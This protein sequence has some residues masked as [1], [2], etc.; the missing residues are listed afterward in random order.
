MIL[1]G[2][3]GLRIAVHDV[4]G[5]TEGAGFF[6]PGEEKAK[7]RVDNYLWVGDREK[8]NLPKDSEGWEATIRS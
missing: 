1:T 2:D 8:A 6:Q 4:R 3:E 5:V 7:G